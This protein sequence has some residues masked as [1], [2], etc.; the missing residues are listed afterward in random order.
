MAQSLNLEKLNLFIAWLDNELSNRGWSDSQLAKRAGITH[1]V[2]SKARN[3][4]QAIGFEACI[5]IADA[6]NLPPELVLQNAGLLPQSDHAESSEISH[7]YQQLEPEDR[8][9]ILDIA[10]VF[11]KNSARK[12]FL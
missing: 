10:R 9:R 11:Q 6:L 2:L 1:P 7:I 5:K 3:G 12:G 8:Q 4:T